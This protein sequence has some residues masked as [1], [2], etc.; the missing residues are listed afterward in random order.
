MDAKHIWKGLPPHIHKANDNER[1]SKYAND[2]WTT[3]H[4]Y[5]TSMGGFC[6]V[7]RSRKGDSQD[8][9]QAPI[10]TDI[11]TEILGYLAPKA[12][13]QLLYSKRI[14]LQALPSA[15]DI[16]DKG[17][18]DGVIKAFALLQ[19]VWVLIQSIARAIQH[20][21]L[22]TLEI[23]TLAYI[24]C[25]VFLFY[26]W[27]DKPYDVS[28]PTMLDVSA[29]VSATSFWNQLSWQE[30]VSNDHNSSQNHRPEGERHPITITRYQT[31]RMTRECWA[32][33]RSTLAP[34]NRLGL[35]SSSVLLIV[36]GIHLAAW[37][38]SFP[39]TYE[40]WAWR[41]ASL[42]ITLSIPLSWLLTRI[43]SSILE[44]GFRALGG[45]DTVPDDNFWLGVGRGENGKT[46]CEERMAVVF[47][48]FGVGLYALA[49]LYLLGEVFA[50]LRAVP[51]GVY[52][53]PD[54]TMF[55]PHVS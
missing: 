29:F 28:V 33:L 55:I 30:V 40:M 44:T 26:L 1:K 35:L 50:S 31:Y 51:K 11:D 14:G 37:N 3:S 20:L 9:F 49:R 27:W 5:Y 7:R 34:I 45:V 18:A 25:A 4:K 21:P 10:G 13:Y 15:D 48:G 22:T 17:K 41:A 42:T 39:S 8:D 24:P 23:T 16:C 12:M 38:F 36:G 46:V 52:E 2:N 54:W 6:L 32:A 47:Q 19:I 53:T 43:C